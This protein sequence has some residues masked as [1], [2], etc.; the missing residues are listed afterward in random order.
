[1]L[2]ESELY[3][4]RLVPY[5]RPA[6]GGSSRGYNPE[7]GEDAKITQPGTHSKRAGYPVFRSDYW[8]AASAAVRCTLGLG[9]PWVWQSTHLPQC[10]LCLL[11][12]LA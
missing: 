11:A 5:T 8:P 2:A 12:G 10:T 6:R 4:G 3:C 7:P 9:T 1:M